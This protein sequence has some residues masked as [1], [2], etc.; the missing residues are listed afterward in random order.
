MIHNRRD[1]NSSLH[2]IPMYCQQNAGAIKLEKVDQFEDLRAMRCNIQLQLQYILVSCSREIH[3]TLPLDESW[4]NRNKWFPS[5]I[6]P[7]HI[8]VK[9]TLCSIFRKE[10]TFAGRTDRYRVSLRHL[11]NATIKV[12]LLHY[13]HGS[14]SQTIFYTRWMNSIKFIPQRA[15]SASYQAGPDWITWRLF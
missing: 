10:I 8:G 3:L 15:D 14:L 5:E 1:Y 6:L 13:K 9:T 4:Y 2:K 12:S 7:K 11:I